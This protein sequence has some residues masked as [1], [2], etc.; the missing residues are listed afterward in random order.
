VL[1]QEL[2][3]YLLPLTME[4]VGRA[5]SRLRLVV[6]QFHLIVNGESK[7]LSEVKLGKKESK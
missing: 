3:E 1:R 6:I 5:C 7:V 4:A 2:F